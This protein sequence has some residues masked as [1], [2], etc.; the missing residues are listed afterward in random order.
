MVIR[1]GTKCNVVLKVNTDKIEYNNYA[2]YR[3]AESGLLSLFGKDCSAS[4]EDEL[5]K[6]IPNGIIVKNAK[7]NIFEK[8][9]GNPA[10]KEMCAAYGYDIEK[11]FNLDGN[12]ITKEIDSMH[13][14]RMLRKQQRE[15]K[16][17]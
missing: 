17:K 8:N 2:V 11:V 9:N 4:V 3:L 6:G 10:F 16:K 13:H 7:N 5:L 1:L 15:N 12:D 14:D